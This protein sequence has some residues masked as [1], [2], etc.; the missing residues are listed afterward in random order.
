MT[1]TACG[2]ASAREHAEDQDRAPL[3]RA[4]PQSNPEVRRGE[5]TPYSRNRHIV[6]ASK[7]EAGD[8]QESTP[9]TGDYQGLSSTLVKPEQFG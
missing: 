7:R 1:R 3:S 8:P 6:C 5:A 2:L 9:E 4:Q